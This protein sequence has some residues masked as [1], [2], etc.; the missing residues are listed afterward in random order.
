MPV[1][2]HTRG[3][4][5]DAAKEAPRPRRS[6]DFSPRSSHGSALA[7]VSRA[8]LEPH[9]APHRVLHFEDDGGFLILDAAHSDLDPNELGASV[10]APVCVRCLLEQHPSVGR[11]MDVAQRTGGARLIEG[12]W[13]EEWSGDE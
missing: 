4:G 7:A 1:C 6:Q 2:A 11:G 9:T 10:L 5:Y 13:L 12:Q 8:L 3:D